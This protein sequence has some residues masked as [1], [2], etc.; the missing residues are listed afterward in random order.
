MHFAGPLGVDSFT[1]HLGH[2]LSIHLFLYP[3][4]P[5]PIH[6]ST[7]L[8]IHLSI[9]P[10]THPIYPRAHTAHLIHA[11]IHRLQPFILS[12]CVLPS[13]HLAISLPSHPLI[14]LS[15]QPLV[16]PLTCP[17]L[18]PPPLHLLIPL[19]VCPPI[20]LTHSSLPPSLHP[21]TSWT[22]C[23]Y[24]WTHTGQGWGVTPHPPFD[25]QCHPW[26]TTGPPRP[27]R[28]FW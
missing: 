3:S 15:L 25:L 17:A 7:F 24:S 28:V 26:Q 20:P 13:T 23:Q 2:H 6:P 18:F 8:S 16:R 22:S 11:C 9:H 1:H 4:H 27:L 12:S 14:H 5:P 19:L 21:G 10:S